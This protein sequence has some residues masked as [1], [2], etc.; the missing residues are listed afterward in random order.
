MS[1]GKR[2]AATAAVWIGYCYALTCGA[3]VFE[4]PE[5]WFWAVLSSSA[6]ATVLIW[7]TRVGD[8]MSDERAGSSRELH[9]AH[10]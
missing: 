2:L 8:G 10:T 5:I 1:T 9:G 6:I 3:H 7:G 4:R